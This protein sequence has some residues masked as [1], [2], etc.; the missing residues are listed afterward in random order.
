MGCSPARYRT[1]GVLCRGGVGTTH[2]ADGLNQKL[3]AMKRP[4]NLPKR[5]DW[6][7]YFDVDATSIGERRARDAVDKIED[8]AAITWTVTERVD[9]VTHARVAVFPCRIGL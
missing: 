2:L 1:L 3:G 7:L 5:I 6:T 4:H 8:P 9:Q